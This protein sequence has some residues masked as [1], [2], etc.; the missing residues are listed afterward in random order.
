MLPRC[1]LV[2]N[3]NTPHVMHLNAKV[4]LECEWAKTEKRNFTFTLHAV[5]LALSIAAASIE[6]NLVSGSVSIYSMP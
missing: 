3:F 4:I 2:T 1:L 5:H 6:E